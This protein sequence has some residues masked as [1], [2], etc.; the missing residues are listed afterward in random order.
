PAFVN[1]NQPSNILPLDLVRSMIGFAGIGDVTKF[2]ALGESNYNALQVQLNKRFGSR[3][4]FAGNYTWQKTIN[5]NHNQFVPDKL[6]KD[7][8]NR[9]QAVNISTTYALPSVTRILGNNALIRGVLEGWHVDSVVQL[10]SGNPLGITCN[11]QSAPAGYPNGQ[12]GLPNG[13]PFRC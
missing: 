5:Y 3:L 6:I 4:T 10:F 12:D 9:K 1:P 7:V 11:V 13:M 2:T 8:L